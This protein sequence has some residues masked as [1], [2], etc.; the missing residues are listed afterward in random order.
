[1]NGKEKEMFLTNWEKKYN[2][3]SGWVKKLQL[4]KQHSILRKENAQT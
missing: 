2:K 3:T 4:N 1:M